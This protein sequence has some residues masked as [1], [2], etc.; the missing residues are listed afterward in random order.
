MN[1]RVTSV[2]ALDDYKLELT[3][4][5]GKVGIF[6]VQPYLD[7]PVYQPLKQASL[8]RQAKIVF[9]TVA[10]SSDIDMS[11]DNLYLECKMFNE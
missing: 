1:P 8:F 4:D 6:S 2:M 5:N 7:F 9:G 11:P 3:F 10:W